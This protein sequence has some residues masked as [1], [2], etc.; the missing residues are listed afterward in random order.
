[1]KDILSASFFI[2]VYIIYLFVNDVSFSWLWYLVWGLLGCVYTIVRHIEKLEDKI[3]G[4]NCYPFVLRLFV[5]INVKEKALDEK[6]KDL[7]KECKSYSSFKQEV[8]YE[9]RNNEQYVIFEGGEKVN[10][11]QIHHGKDILGSMF[12]AAYI[13]STSRS[14]QIFKDGGKLVFGS[15]IPYSLNGYTEKKLVKYIPLIIDLKKGFRVSDKEIFE[16]DFIKWFFDIVNCYSENEN[17]YGIWKKE[18]NLKKITPKGFT[19]TYH[20]DEYDLEF[21]SPHWLEF[22]NEMFTISVTP[23]IN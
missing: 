10:F 19:V 15:Q 18:E 23:E 16:I 21:H 2:L 3:R 22:E 6:I 20:P 17:T 11:K 1:M 13:D 7:L 9:D 12:F 4:I 8:I 14:L 5:C